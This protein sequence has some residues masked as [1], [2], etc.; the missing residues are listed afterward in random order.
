MHTLVSLL[1]LPPQATKFIGLLPRH[2]LHIQLN[3]HLIMQLLPALS[4]FSHSDTLA[5]LSHVIH[6]SFRSIYSFSQQSHVFASLVLTLYRHSLQSGLP[7][8][9]V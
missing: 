2:L 6:R 8:S 1:S 3:W 9:A 7:G 5:S 4:K